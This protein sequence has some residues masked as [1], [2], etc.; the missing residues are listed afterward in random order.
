MAESITDSN[1][2]SVVI[3]VPGPV[4]VDFWAPW[5]SPCR[6]LA[7]VID[8]L[9]ETFAG[10]VSIYKLNVDESPK[11]P[12]DYNIRA[13]PTLILFKNG[14]VVDQLT[15]AVSKNNLTEFLNKKALA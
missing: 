12:V 8:E 9:T 6:A 2:K 10:K 5:C 14:Q 13:I 7:P 11:A 4:L 3:D 1:F 15:G